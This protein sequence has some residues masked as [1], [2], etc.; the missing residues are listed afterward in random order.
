MNDP[1]FWD[2]ARLGLGAFLTSPGAGLI[3]LL[4]AAW[5]TFVGVGKRIEGDKELARDARRD[6]HERQ[7]EADA[8][9]RWQWFYERLWENRSDLPADALLHG[10]RSLRALAATQEQSAMLEVL[11]RYVQSEAEEDL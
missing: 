9:E 8:R 7:L 1:T 4:G 5:L 6:E 2:T 10:M 3:G 11:A